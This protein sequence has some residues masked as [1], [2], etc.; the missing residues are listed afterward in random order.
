M[1]YW[2]K[3]KWICFCH[4]EGFDQTV[5]TS[6]TALT[7][8]HLRLLK[9]YTNNLMLVYDADQAGMKA[10]VKAWS[11]ALKHGLEVKV[12]LLPKNEDPASL[13]LEDKGMFVHALK[14]AM[15]VI[16]YVLSKS[17]IGSRSGKKDTMEKLIPLVAALDNSVDRE[18]FTKRIADVFDMSLDSVY[19]EVQ[20]YKNADSGRNMDGQSTFTVGS[21]IEQGGIQL[22]D[23]Q[24]RLV[25]IRQSLAEFK[26]LLYI[27]TQQLNRSQTQSDGAM[28]PDIYEKMKTNMVEYKTDV[29]G[30]VQNEY[31]PGF[32]VDID[33]CIQELESTQFTVDERLVYNIENIH[34]GK[35]TNTDFYE[36]E[37]N[38]A[39]AN[40]I[41]KIFT[42]MFDDVKNA[43]KKAEAIK[44]TQRIDICSD[45]IYQL[46]IY[47]TKIK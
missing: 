46:S 19:T 3:G 35:E 28:R 21:V 22:V 29:L 17:D 25:S 41:H 6:G 14:N 18:H 12:A 24:D 11:L 40:V 32:N 43:L 13:L 5:A 26:A 36:K 39:Y 4:Q 8:D 2:L 45:Y 9:R 16:E 42:L 33:T 20:R 30:K 31:Y 37:I 38:I 10:T 15:H 23:G 34:S 47:K 7:D 27:Y 44:D 1:P